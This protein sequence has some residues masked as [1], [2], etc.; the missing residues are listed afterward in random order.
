MRAEQGLEVTAL[1]SWNGSPPAPRNSILKPSKLSRAKR[2]ALIHSVAEEIVIFQEKKKNSGNISKQ[3]CQSY[4]HR[5]YSPKTT[6]HRGTSQHTLQ[7]QLHHKAIN[8]L[9][10][11]ETAPVLH[12]LKSAETMTQTPGCSPLTQSDS[13][14][15]F[16]PVFELLV[17]LSARHLK[18]SHQLASQL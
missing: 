17:G 18:S 3:L 15:V 2:R 5:I 14:R 10:L 8:P 12:Q 1:P 9:A 4:K 13:S 16:P 11:A 6:S 7:P